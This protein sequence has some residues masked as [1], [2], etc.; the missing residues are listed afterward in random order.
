MPTIKVRRDGE[1]HCFHC[2]APVAAD[3]AR[4][5]ECGRDFV[6]PDP[7]RP[8]LT[9]KTLTERMKA[10]A[11]WRR[12][13]R[14][15]LRAVIL[16]ALLGVV[17]LLV[18]PTRHRG[19]VLPQP[20]G[21]RPEL[22]VLDTREMP[23]RGFDRLTLVLLGSPEG[24]NDQLRLLMDWALYEAVVRYNGQQKRNV[25]VVWLYVVTDASL[26]AVKWR[27]MAIWIDPTLHESLRP[28]GNGGDALKAGAV[29]YDFTNPVV[30]S[31]PPKS[32]G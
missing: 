28:A 32:G 7:N 26:P 13:G 21:V 6:E 29:E 27:A 9:D 15:Y 3:A 22:R 10:Q 30:T 18:W 11:G 19:P 5:P 4:C 2:N 20:S 8:A 31:V 16:L 17:V 25:R 23:A 14:G 12:G 24:D 1:V